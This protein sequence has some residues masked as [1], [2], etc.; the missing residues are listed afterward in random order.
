MREALAEVDRIIDFIDA[1]SP[2]RDQQSLAYSGWILLLYS[3]FEKACREILFASLLSRSLSL[4]E[5]GDFAVSERMV[6]V[7]GQSR[8]S[9]GDDEVKVAASIL[10]NPERIADFDKSWILRSAT[11]WPSVVVGEMPL[12]AGSSGST[13][14]SASNVRLP[15][16]VRKL[17]A[18]LR[19]RNEIAHNGPTTQLRDGQIVIDEDAQAVRAF[20]KELADLC[21]SSI[22]E[23]HG[24]SAGPVGDR[25]LEAEAQLGPQTLAFARIC[26]ELRVGDRVVQ[27]GGVRLTVLSMQSDSV[28]MEV[29]SAGDE[30]VA[31]TLNKPANP[32][33]SI[34][35]LL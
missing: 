29:C 31:V 4:G 1:G 27:A 35:L 8:L 5:S 30:R 2:R 22:F 6:R 20:V 25:D 12:A 33:A 15:G 28:E 19:E 17:E 7:I 16:S 34:E 11:A 9:D 24:L 10:A 32:S 13:L 21:S 3:T 14:T 23:A 26:G 18:L